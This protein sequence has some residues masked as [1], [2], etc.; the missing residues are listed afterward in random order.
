MN[1]AKNMEFIFV[2]AII[3]VGGTSMATAKAIRP[4]VRGIAP[5]AVTAQ[6]AQAPMPVVVVSAKRLN[7]AEKAAL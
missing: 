7:A 6:A 5:P 1:I 4:V 2:A 3:L